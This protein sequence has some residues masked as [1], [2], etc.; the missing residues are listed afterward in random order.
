MWSGD[1]YQL[2]LAYFQT[3]LADDGWKVF[4]GMFPQQLLYGLV[5]GDMGHPAGGTD[6]NDCNSM[7]ARTVVEGMFGYRPDY[8][9]G[10]VTVAPQFPS[11]WDHA[12]IH[13]PDM[14]VAYRT[15]LVAPLAASARFGGRAHQS[16]RHGFGITGWSAVSAAPSSTR[17][18]RPR[19]AAS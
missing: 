3:G 13:T 14:S 4:H 7:F 16:G 19:R 17:G 15:S 6:F 1:D 18:G 8:T 12:S 11:D 2:A 10:L 9:R 5:P